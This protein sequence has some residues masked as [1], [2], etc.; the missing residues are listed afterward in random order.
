MEQRK[1]VPSLS[2]AMK[3]LIFGEGVERMVRKF[4]YLD[5]NGNFMGPR[6]VAKE[7]RFVEENES[8]Y[9]SRMDY[10]QEF[11]RTQVLARVMAAKFNEALNNLT[12][13]FDLS[14]RE[15]LKKLPR[16]RFWNLWFSNLS[17]TAQA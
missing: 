16:I 9:K 17:E 10:H 3:N 6:F 2:V 4:R 7:S 13:H 5:D 15:W 11:M 1:T 8:T 14:Y 12:S